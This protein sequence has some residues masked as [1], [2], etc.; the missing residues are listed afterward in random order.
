MG[1]LEIVKDSKTKERFESSDRAGYEI[2]KIAMKHG[3][4]LR[5]LGDTMYFMPPFIIT[6][7]EIDKMLEICKI[8]IEEYIKSRK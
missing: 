2:Y 5:P 7:E 3:A 4:I 1:A 6:Y 8:S